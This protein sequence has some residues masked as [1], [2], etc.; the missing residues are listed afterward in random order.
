MG[1]RGNLLL[2]SSIALSGTPKAHSGVIRD[3]NVVLVPLAAAAQVCPHAS[4]PSRA[5]RVA[6]AGTHTP[7]TSP[8]K[9]SNLLLYFVTEAAPTCFYIGYWGCTNLLL[10][11]LPGSQQG[12]WEKAS[13]PFTSD[14]TDFAPKWPKT[15]KGK[16]DIFFF[17]KK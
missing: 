1:K 9:K 2:H 3:A 15:R 7:K 14:L 10:F 16:F 17:G 12:T 11:P 6:A 13:M 8:K 5:P 4:D